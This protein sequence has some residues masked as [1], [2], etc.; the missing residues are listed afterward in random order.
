VSAIVFVIR[1]MSRNPELSLVPI[2][3]QDGEGGD[4]EDEAGDDQDIDH[5]EVE[6]DDAEESEGGGED[7]DMELAPVDSLSTGS[8]DDLGQVQP[9]GTQSTPK[10]NTTQA[11]DKAPTVTPTPAAGSSSKKRDKRGESAEE[12][13]EGEEG[14]ST[15]G[16][17]WVMQRL[18]GLGS[19]PRGRKRLHVIRVSDALALRASHAMIF[20]RLQPL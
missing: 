17:R 19:D 18:K 20:L 11:V 12:G 10:K 8:D 5:E 14:D 9:S 13:V 2:T 7:E 3:K 16:C 1:A 4:V 6:E 15:D